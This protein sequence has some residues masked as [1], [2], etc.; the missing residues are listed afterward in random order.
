M[1]GA[2]AAGVGNEVVG[3]CGG[4]VTLVVWV[5]V[6]NISLWNRDYIRTVM[7]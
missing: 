7:F 4:M 5:E 6:M 2:V 3:T 1:A